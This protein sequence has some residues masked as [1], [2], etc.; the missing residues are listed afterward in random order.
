MA[1]SARPAIWADA[2]R[3]ALEIE[4][5]VRG[6]A[7]YHKYTLGA[8][9]RR[10]AAQICRLVAQAAR[11]AR[12]RAAALERLVLEVEALKTT[13]YLAK[14]LQAFA[15]FAQ[16]ERV[17]QLA[18]LVGKQSGGWFKQAAKRPVAVDSTVSD[19]GSSA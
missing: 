13:I 11:F 6:F 14:E 17:V 3:L 7:R 19:P 2:L 1:R 12:H 8:D 4:Q 18:V 10:Q 5:A 15:S 9:L 16:F